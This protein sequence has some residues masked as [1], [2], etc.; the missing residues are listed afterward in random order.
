MR[1]IKGSYIM[2]SWFINVLLN[3]SNSIHSAFASRTRLLH[4]SRGSGRL[5]FEGRGK[6][7]LSL[8]VPANNISPIQSLTVIRRQME[9]QE[10]KNNPPSQSMD[11]TLNQNEAELRIF[12]FSIRLEVLSNG[13]SLFDEVPEIFRDGWS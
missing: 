6:L 4:E 9:W 1:V 13:D 11:P 10:R 7:L 12:V 3:H 2:R 5:V 8:I